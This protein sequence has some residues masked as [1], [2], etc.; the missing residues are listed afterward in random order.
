MI[1]FFTNIFWLWTALCVIQRIWY[2]WKIAMREL[3]SRNINRLADATIEY[4]KELLANG[5]KDKV[6][7]IVRQ[8]G[9]SLAQL[10]EGVWKLEDMIPA[11]LYFE[12]Y[13]Y[14]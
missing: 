1:K 6:Q 2:L 13:P 8:V 14:F 7:R 3:A 9:E 12:L 11:Q 4:G 10:P 5:E